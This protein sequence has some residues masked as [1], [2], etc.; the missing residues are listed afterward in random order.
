MSISQENKTLQFV[1][2]NKRKAYKKARIK[3][4]VYVK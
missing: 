2:Q 1:Y 3:E 4:S